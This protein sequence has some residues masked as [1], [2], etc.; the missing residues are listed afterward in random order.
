MAQTSVTA[1]DSFDDEVLS[2]F[3]TAHRRTGISLLR[4]LEATAG[5]EALSE[6]LVQKGLLAGDELEGARNAAAARLHEQYAEAGLAILISEGVPD[7]YDLDEGAAAEVDCDSRRH[8]CRSACCRMRFALTRQDIDEGVVRW[9]LGKPYL[10]RQG[11]DGWCT[12]I[13]GEGQCGV[14]EHRP[15]ICRTYD[16]SSD[17]RIWAD[18]DQGVIS[19][20]LAA[21][22][23]ELDAR[24]GS[25]VPV[26]APVLRAA[27]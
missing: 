11:P 22:Y 21:I 18:F 8:L 16:C 24:E 26:A 3:R 23:A 12:H 15:V 14:Y 17:T 25:W 7:K 19:D 20:E 2:G 27:G 6:L 5:L 13:D 1:T 10:N 4:T 9:E